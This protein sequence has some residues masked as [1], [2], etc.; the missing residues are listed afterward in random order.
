MLT[1]PID[2]NRCCVLTETIVDEEL[3]MVLGFDFLL[4]YLTLLDLWLFPKKARAEGL[5]DMD[6]STLSVDL[7]MVPL[8]Q[9]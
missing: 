6:T 9:D 2:R 8:S 3:F 5:F 4:V 1:V 7:A